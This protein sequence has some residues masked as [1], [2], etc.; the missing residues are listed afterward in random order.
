MINVS[1][2]CQSTL[3]LIIHSKGS[4]K[5]LKQGFS[6]QNYINTFGEIYIIFMNQYPIPRKSHFKFMLEVYFFFKW[7]T[8]R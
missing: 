4:E 1:I 2:N 8:T 5:I 6:S 3:R 7:H